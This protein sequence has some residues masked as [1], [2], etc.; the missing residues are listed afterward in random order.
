[1]SAAG[2]LAR[3]RASEVILRNLGF[4]GGKPQ[5]IEVSC[6]PTVLYRF[7][8]VNTPGD[9]WQTLC[10]DLRLQEIETYCLWHTASAHPRALPIAS[11]F[12]FLFLRGTLHDASESD[13]CSARHCSAH[14]YA[15]PLA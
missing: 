7:L 1:M 3:A 9:P 10:I 6:R 4:E 11:S 8:K 15:R 5:N 2:A 13:T 14:A 12:L